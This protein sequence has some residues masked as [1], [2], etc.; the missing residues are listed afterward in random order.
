VIGARQATAADAPAIARTLRAAFDHDPFWTWLIGDRAGACVGAIT[1]S[2]AA[3]HPEQ[4]TVTDDLQ[5]AAWWHPPGEWRLTFPEILR[6][7]PDVLPT[8]RLGAIRLLRMSALVERQHPPEPAAYL[9]YLGAAPASQGQGR[10]AAAL[11]PALAVC[12]AFGWPAFLES[13][14]P[15][16]LPFYR[17]Q[18]FVD[19]PALR[20]PAGC[21]VVTPMWRAAQ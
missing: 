21:P 17:R 11:A 1:G 4:F 6:L 13:S 14:N 15:R 20:V 12:D 2:G 19:R 3:R 5:A 16:N 7:L 9:G 18:G 10:G 8:A